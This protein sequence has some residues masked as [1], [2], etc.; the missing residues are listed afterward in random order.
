ML[1]KALLC[2]R[3]PNKGGYIGGI[4]TLCNDYIDKA[5]LFRDHG[6]EI[7]NFNYS[8]PSHGI[9]AK[10]RNSKIRNILYGIKQIKA[11]RNLLKSSPE[12]TIHIHTSRRALFYKDVILARAIRNCCK[13]KI[14][15]TVHVG[16]INTVFGNKTAMKFLIKQI[17]RSVDTVVFLSKKMRQ[18]FIDAGLE[19]KHAEVIYNFYNIKSISPEKKL[20]NKTPQITFLGSINREK[21]IIEL[22]KSVLDITAD[23]HLNLCGTII[24]EDIK[25]DFEKLL[26]RLGTKATFHG[27]VNKEQKEKILR[28]TDILVLPSYREGLPISILEALATSCGIITTPVG[29]IPE[30]LKDENAII[31][32][33]K[34]SME[35]KRAIEQLLS[36]K[37][38]LDNMRINNYNLS[39]SFTDE[40]H[41]TKLCALYK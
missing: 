1:H 9:Y 34:D 31:V 29:A 4:A 2:F 3:K 22:L 5:Q 16:D 23:F 19:N 13:G 35:L 41:I 15:M 36:D 14:V 8:L 33:P 7:D 40:T 39:R 25:P 21:G 37:K 6:I 20:S 18:Q 11:L 12:T 26:N 17:Y 32:K 27:Y 28:E 24:E 38:L 10:V 30:I